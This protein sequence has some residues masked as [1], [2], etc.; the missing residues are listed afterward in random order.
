MGPKQRRLDYKEVGVEG[1][2][3]QPEF[4]LYTN[5]GA[6]LHVTVGLPPVPIFAG[7]SRFSARIP[8]SRPDPCRDAQCPDI[9]F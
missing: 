9:W 4:R 2:R 1:D 8:A 5:S 3:L 7:T 6:S